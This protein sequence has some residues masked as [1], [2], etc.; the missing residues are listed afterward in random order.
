MLEEHA[1]SSTALSSGMVD[2]LWAQTYAHALARAGRRSEAVS[3]QSDVLEVLD[4]PNH[5]DSN[6]LIRSA[7]VGAWLGASAM[8]S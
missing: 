2:A 7:A 4:K 6:G 5:L 1:R 3:I 8:V